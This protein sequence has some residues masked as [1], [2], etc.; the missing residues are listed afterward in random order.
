MRAGD[1]LIVWRL[2]RLGRSLKHL[3][4][5]VNHLAEREIGFQSLQE[6][7]DTTIDDGQVI[8]Q[9]FATLAEFQRNTMRERTLVGL[10]AARA[11]GRNGGRPKA[12]DAEKTALLYKLYDEKRHTIQELFQMMGVSKATL[13]NYMKER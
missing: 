8:F 4:D 6:S 9:T 1:I 13:Y 12:L 10:Q 2:E 3:V 7:I 5:I 11:R